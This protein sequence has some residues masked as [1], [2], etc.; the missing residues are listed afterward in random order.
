MPHAH[1]HLNIALSRRTNRK[2]L[3][4]GNIPKIISLSE[5]REKGKLA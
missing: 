5:S 3:R 4:N 1:L 2:R